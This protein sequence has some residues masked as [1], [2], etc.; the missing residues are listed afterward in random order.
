MR[1]LL[2]QKTDPNLT[3]KDGSTALLWASRK[4]DI[5]AANLLIQAGAKAT[6][7]NRY[8]ATAIGLACT[9]GSAPMVELLLNAGVDSNTASPEGETALMTC[10]RA[11][12]VD[13]VQS[14]LKRGANVNQRE[15]WRGQTALMWA[16]AEGHT[17]V[18]KALLK[19][20]ADPHLRA[21]APPAKTNPYQDAAKTAPKRRT[22][23]TDFT[24]LLF[25]VREG[26]LETVRAF[27]DAGADPNEA[28][29][30]GQ[31]ALHIA[32]LNANYEIGVLLMDKGAKPN[33]DACGWTALHQV[34]W[35]R[36]PNIHKTPAALGSGKMES[37]EFTKILLAR[38][39]DV[40]ARATKD[41]IDGNL[42]KLKR[43]GATAFLLAAKSGDY[44]YMRF[45]G[46]LNADARIMTNEHV[47]ALETAAGI[48][49]Y[50]VAESP[51]TNEESFQCVKAAYELAHGDPA[52]VNHIDDNGRTALH[53]A[54]F[55]GSP[56]IV[57]YLI[58]H[59]AGATI[60][61]KDYL[62]WTAL[63]IAEGVMW[64]T[65]LKTELP[66]AELLAKL[67]A[68]HEDV[69]EEVKM[70]GMATQGVDN[71]LDQTMGGGGASPAQPKT[72]ATPI[73]IKTDAGDVCVTPIEHAS[74]LLTVNGKNIYIDPS[75][76]KYEGRPAADLILI[77]DIHADHFAPT[78]IGQISKKDTVIWGPKAVAAKTKVDTTIGN[79]ETQNW[80][81]WTIEAVPA[82]NR[83]RGE[84]AGKVYHDKGR[85][86]GYVLTFGGKRI[87]FSGDTEDLPEMAALKNI[88]V[89]FICM[90]LPYTM[91][92]EEAALAVQRFHPKVVYPYHYRGSNL[93][94]FVAY[95][96]GTGIEVQIREWYPNK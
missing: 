62:G 34:A 70:L 55:R 96:K 14:L 4:N 25:A 50:R 94:S 73:V 12:T 52:Y 77:T 42:G 89:A 45:L 29:S 33:A 82:Y 22:N 83:I 74:V 27:L 31:T 60:N 64:P 61:H 86:N 43:P 24:A 36:R 85:G 51:G 5:A 76:G 63:T 59:G 9:N 80:G 48:G 68:K 69:P 67:G 15:T 40:N 53:G 41:P 44:E 13:A 57:Q 6:T 87:Y 17:E 66:T 54:A 30:D 88:D 78:I 28:L 8:G 81:D 3:A 93:N 75:Q 92:P 37:L 10:A 20:G 90:N 39:A 23:P 46:T 58:D 11:G 2:D 65:V 18:V 49:I 26:Q 16:A 32:A 95:T 1:K 35:T 56:E 21:K 7:A 91:T 47:T 38:G 71:G 84:E 72:V 79:G 19:A